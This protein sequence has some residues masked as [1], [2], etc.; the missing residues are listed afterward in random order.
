MSLCVRAEYLSKELGY[1]WGGDKVSS[2]AK[3]IALGVVP[4]CGV[5]KYFLH[6]LHKFGS[7]GSFSKAFLTER[8]SIAPCRDA[9]PH[10]HILS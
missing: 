3:H 5:C 2:T 9:G 4:C 1:F 8:G 10:R 6:K 7:D